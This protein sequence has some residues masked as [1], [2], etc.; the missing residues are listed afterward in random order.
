M[1]HAD[2]DNLEVSIA[3]LSDAREQGAYVLDVRR[4]EEYTE[5]HVPG[6]VH[7]ALDQLA[8]RWGEVPK[9]QRVYVICASGHRSLV[10][11]KALAEAGVDA[12]SVAG[13]TKAWLAEGRPAATGTTPG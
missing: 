10:A 9:D 13:G 12:V 1:T 6:A 7:I 11:A 5:A 8:D 2:T 4:D 3:D